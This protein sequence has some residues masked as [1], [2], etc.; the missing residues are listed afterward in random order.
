MLDLLTVWKFQISCLVREA[1]A[2]LF[3]VY[4]ETQLHET[5][6]FCDRRKKVWNVKRLQKMPKVFFLWKM[7]RKSCWHILK[8]VCQGKIEDECCRLPRLVKAVSGTNI[9]TARPIQLSYYYVKNYLANLLGQFF[10]FCKYSNIVE[11]LATWS[12]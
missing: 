3:H 7:E 4:A 6:T 11:K 8:K 12:L 1:W 5:L 10:H 2:P 9:L